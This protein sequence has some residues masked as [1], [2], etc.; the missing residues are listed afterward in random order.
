[1]EVEVALAQA[2]EA[3]DIFSRSSMDGIMTAE[4]I[5]SQYIISIM[6]DDKMLSHGWWLLVIIDIMIILCN[7][8]PWI[9]PT[10]DL[11][12]WPIEAATFDTRRS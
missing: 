9:Q 2:V 5:H 8:H 3:G 6:E 12:P 11:S 4:R 7:L 1:M 10:Y